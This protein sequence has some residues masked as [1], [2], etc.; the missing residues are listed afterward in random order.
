MRTKIGIGLVLGAIA[1]IGVFGYVVGLYS[2]ERHIGF[3][4]PVWD[5]TG[6]TVFVLRRTTSGFVW[7]LGWEFF[8]PP[9]SSY[10]AS[11]SFELLRVTPGQHDSEV[12]ARWS[13]SPLVGRVTQHYR[14]R[15]FNYI[16]ARLDPSQ[17]DIRVRVRMSI[18]RIPSSE[19]WSVDTVWKP[20]DAFHANWVEGSPGGL[21]RSEATLTAGREVL[22]VLGKEGFG[23]AVVI[24]DA[25][26]SHSILIKNGD[27]DALYPNGVAPKL[28]A[29]RSIRKQIE[30]VRD[31]RKV[32]AELVKR[33]MSEEGLREGDAILRAYDEMEKLGYLPRKPRITAT[34]VPNLPGNVPV[35]DIPRLYLDAGLFQ[36][37]AKAIRSPGTAVK[38]GLG[39]Y[40]KYEDDDF[41]LRLKT[42]REAG[43]NRF[44]VRIDGRLFL[45]EQD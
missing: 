22:T 1:I 12:L 10:V 11:D 42:F 26:G 19:V 17:N 39:T 6:K 40:L 18:P 14:G 35:F 16:S 28:I 45:I 2:Y 5:K 7:G 23:A 29:E 37:I 24:V 32:Q 8:T 21:A 13:G 41:G 38:T 33:F 3:F 34:L 31:F 20:Q 15:I 30:S 43:G 4:A 9:A 44:G 36:D 27:F 25:D